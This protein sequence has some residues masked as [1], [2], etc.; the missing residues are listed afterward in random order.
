VQLIGANLL[1]ENGENQ[2]HE[3]RI[4]PCRK[5]IAAIAQLVAEASKKH[6]AKSQICHAV[7]IAVEYIS[8]PYLM[9]HPDK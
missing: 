7:W 8:K 3:Y 2:S 4:R 1:A 9:K 5:S 6:I